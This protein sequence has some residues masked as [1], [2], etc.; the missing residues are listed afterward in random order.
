M[1]LGVLKS[2]CGEYMHYVRSCRELGIEHEVVDIIAPDWMERVQRSECDGFLCRP[3][4]KVQERKTMFD[5]RLTVLNRFMKREIYPSLDEMLIYEN[6]RMAHYW[7]K[8]QGFPHPDTWIFYRKGDLSKFLREFK[9]YPLISKTNIGAQSSGVRVLRS[10]GAVKRIGRMVFGIFRTPSLVPG[11]TPARSGSLLKVPA[12]GL[13]EKHS[14]FLQ[15]FEDIKWE[16]RMVRIG[17]SYFGHRKLLGK[18]GLAS[19]THLKGWGAPPSELLELTREICD[20]GGFQS[21][22]IDILETTDGRYLVNELQSI[23]GQPVDNLMYVDGVPGRYVED[24]DGFVFQEGEF[25]AHNSFLLRV[26]HFA[27][28]LGEKR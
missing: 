24:G 28:L 15:R 23:F 6:K 1:K 19:G 18:K 17:R 25:N 26:R 2:F 13:R 4:S 5:E 10:P 14:L 21:M 12:Y 9:D 16:W 22:A 27:E 3:P 7:L 8:L 11:Y 20:R